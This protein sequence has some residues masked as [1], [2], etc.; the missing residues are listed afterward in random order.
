MFYLKH[1]GK[2][3]EIHDDNVYN[4]VGYARKAFHGRRSRFGSGYRQTDSGARDGEGWCIT[5]ANYYAAGL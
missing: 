1:K 5:S 4:R 2:R 3:L